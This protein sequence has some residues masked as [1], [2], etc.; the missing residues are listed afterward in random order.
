MSVRRRCLLLSALRLLGL[1]LPRSGRGSRLHEPAPAP[2]VHQVQI[3][4]ELSSG[5]CAHRRS[6]R[7]Q[8]LHGQRHPASPRS[9]RMVP[10]V[11]H[12]EEGRSDNQTTGSPRGR[13]TRNRDPRPQF[14]AGSPAGCTT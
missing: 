2:Q 9:A 10:A 6:R 3:Q 11:S 8:W 5:P 4:A 1:S 14:F 7:D 13:G 12:L